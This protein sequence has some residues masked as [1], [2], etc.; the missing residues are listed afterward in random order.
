M[1]VRD[2]MITR[3]FTV[4]PSNTIKELLTILNSNRIGGT[5]VVDDNGNLVGMVS[6]GDVLRYLTPKPVGFAGLVYII[7]DGDMEDVIQDKMKTPV[8][9]IMTKRNILSVHPD[10]D[11]ER[12]MRLLSMHRYK[13]LPVVN[14]AGRVIGVLSRGDLIDNI[15]KK[16]IV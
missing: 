8:K 14:G 1:K 16:I 12:I 2:F 5:P 13:K 9:E 4:K 6:D 15:T 7:E 10:E 11:F 3:V